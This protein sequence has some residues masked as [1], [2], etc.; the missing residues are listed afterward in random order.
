MS[1]QVKVVIK[2]LV[3]G[4]AATPSTAKIGQMLSPHGVKAIEFCKLFNEKTSARKGETVPVVVT[5]YIDKT[6]DF[7]I[8][9]TAV[10]ELI[11]KKLGID[12][13]AKNPGKDAAVATISNAVL[14]E[15]AKIKMQ[16]LNAFDLDAA[17]KL[18]A[19]SAKSMG[20]KVGDN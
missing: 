11:K 3:P 13:G 6:F 7:A 1:K 15:I 14:E 10:S 9:T 16:D 17:K 8:K 20:I 12:K 4:G 18:I 5:V 2:L 19:G